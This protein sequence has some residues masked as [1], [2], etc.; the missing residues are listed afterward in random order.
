MMRLFKRKSSVL[1]EPSWETI[2]YRSMMKF[3]RSLGCR[4]KFVKL[5]NMDWNWIKN[6]NKV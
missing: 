1:K 3:Y 2:E 6:E 5:K 4:N